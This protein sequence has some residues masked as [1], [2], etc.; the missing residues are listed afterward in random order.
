MT[1][2]R[3]SILGVFLVGCSLFEAPEDRTQLS[4][5]VEAPQVVSQ[6]SAAA[7][8]IV[9]VNESNSSVSFLTAIPDFA[10]RALVSDMNGNV[11]WDR[12]IGVPLTE[13]YYAVTLAPHDSVRFSTSWNLETNGRE[14]V[15]PGTY[16]VSGSV[17]GLPSSLTAPP[18]DLLI[19]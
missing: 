2:F 7:L 9:I 12:L 14:K 8:S 10:F 13:P 16:R 5:R 17:F 18:V 4:L 19:K 3:F 11:L 15:A 1:R 6:D